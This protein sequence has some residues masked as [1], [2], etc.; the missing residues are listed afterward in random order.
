MAGARVQCVV[1]L[2]QCGPGESETIRSLIACLNQ[3]SD[4]AQQL[5]VLIY[6]NSP[7]EHPFV[8]A[9]FPFTSIEYHHDAHN[10]GL[11]SA[12]NHAL[13]LADSG[14]IDWL[15]LLDQDTLVEI[16]LFSSLLQEIES[17]PPQRV[18]AL[19]PRLVYGS[20]MISPLTVGSFQNRPI[21]QNFSGIPASR[22]TALNSAACL[23]T[24]AV[25][26][27]GG[28][29]KEYWLDYLD[30]IVFHRLQ[31]GGDQ[32]FVLDISIQHGL[33]L[34]N[35]ET[36]M[37]Q[38]RYENFLAA[39]WAFIK[40]TGWGGGSLVHRIRLLKRSIVHLLTQNSRSYAL[41]TLK[42]SI[43]QPISHGNG[44]H[45]RFPLNTL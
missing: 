3:S 44:D 41:L 17:T 9:D 43:R 15:L 33:S 2:Y 10:G 16:G 28:F 6:D 8:P 14:R 21:A 45:E 26:R 34:M 19:V 36:E 12:Y 7:V 37:S 35:L 11:T 27:I 4:L 29:P 20:T 38:P 5:A 24:E 18:C 13:A 23:R 32:V 42:S 30:H 40:E 1:V 31:A 25:K 39:E 22:L